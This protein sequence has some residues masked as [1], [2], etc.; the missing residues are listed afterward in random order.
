VSARSK[1]LFASDF[2]SRFVR[3]VCPSAK[4]AEVGFPEFVERPLKKGEA[5]P[6]VSFSSQA[7]TGLYQQAQDA[8]LADKME[9][10]KREAMVDFS[11][12]PA[13]GEPRVG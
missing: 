1:Y 4:P 12:M 13:G 11:A 9:A 2:M 10:D 7:G 6:E 5:F 8:M 3:G